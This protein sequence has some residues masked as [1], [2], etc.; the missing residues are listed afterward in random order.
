MYGG[1]GGHPVWGTNM[2][3]PDFSSP[4][5]LLFLSPPSI[6]FLFF[7]LLPLLLPSPFSSFSSHP[8]LSFFPP[9]FPT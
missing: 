3:Q 9:P 7:F 1:A 8:S 2:P 5:L 4:P 6:S